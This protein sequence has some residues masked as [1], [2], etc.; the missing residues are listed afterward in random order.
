MTILWLIPS[1]S[2]FSVASVVSPISFI[3]LVSMLREAV[4]DLLRH[5]SDR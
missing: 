1:I 5:K 2:P 4:E 3:T